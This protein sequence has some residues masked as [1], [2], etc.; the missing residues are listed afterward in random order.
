[1]QYVIF[2]SD[3][4]FTDI[5]DGQLDQWFIGG[6]CAGWFYARLLPHERIKASLAPQMEDW[7]WIMAVEAAGSVV[8]IR[9][10]EYSDEHKSWVL[11]IEARKKL[12]KKNSADLMESAEMLVAGAV[13]AILESDARF[14]NFRWCDENP[15]EK[16][17]RLLD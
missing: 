5:P 9:V 12:L 8:D 1:M 4:F 7:G 2:E 15:L 17:P 14:V 16:P 3:L 6:D 11:G 13:A 10:W